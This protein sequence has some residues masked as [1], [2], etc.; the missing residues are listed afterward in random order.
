[1]QMGADVILLR[2]FLDRKPKKREAKSQTVNGM[3]SKAFGGERK[4]FLRHTPYNSGYS[5]NGS[6]RKADVDNEKVFDDFFSGG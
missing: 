3:F 1:M 2:E 4:T 5:D 6:P